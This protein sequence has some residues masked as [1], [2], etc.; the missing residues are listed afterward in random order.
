MTRLRTIAALL[1]QAPE[2]RTASPEAIALWQAAG[3][4]QDAGPKGIDAGLLMVVRDKI[5]AMLG[6]T[7]P[8]V[9]DAW[10]IIETLT[11]ADIAQEWRL[12]DA[13]IERLQQLK[14]ER[15]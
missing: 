11:P 5:D 6:P 9:M 8:N 12:A 3:R 14:G 1:E 2:T 13:M 7:R 15:A 10:R 4:M